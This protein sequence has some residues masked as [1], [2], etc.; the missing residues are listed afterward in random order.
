MLRFIL[1]HGGNSTYHGE[2]EFVV[3]CEIGPRSTEGAQESKEHGDASGFA[4]STCP[5]FPQIFVI[6]DRLDIL[7]D[8]NS[9]DPQKDELEAGVPPHVHVDAP[10]RRRHEIH[11]HAIVGSEHL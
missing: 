5:E 4:C 7:D 2:K 6:C 10:G 8:I 1:Y 3:S 9:T 11:P